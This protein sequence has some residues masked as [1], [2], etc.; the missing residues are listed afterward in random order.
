MATVKARR[1]QWAGVEFQPDL[2]KPTSKPV[3][4]GGVLY[5]VLPSGQRSVFVIGRVPRLENRPPEF[6]HVSEMTMALVEDWIDAMLKDIMEAK[7]DDPILYLAS[8]WRWN[9]YV[10]QPARRVLKSQR[11]T[12]DAAAKRYYEQFVGERFKARSRAP[13]VRTRSALASNRVSK[14]DIQ[15][16][17]AWVV[18]QISRSIGPTLTV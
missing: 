9:L 12:L 5:E 8:R 7:P 17:P 11:T 4:L 6:E 14:P 10:V 2:K 15:L 3:R 13:R 1:V 18:E 16:P